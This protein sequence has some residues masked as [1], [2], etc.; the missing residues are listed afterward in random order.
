MGEQQS[1]DVWGIFYNS[2]GISQKLIIG[3]IIKRSIDNTTDD[4]TTY[5]Y[6]PF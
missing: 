4:Y 6:I 1:A 2:K 5:D 3:S